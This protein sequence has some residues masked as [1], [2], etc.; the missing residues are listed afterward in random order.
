MKTSE[1]ELKHFKRVLLQK[2][3][4]T[5]NSDVMYN[6][7][8]KLCENL[9]TEIS[10]ITKKI[11]ALGYAEGDFENLEDSGRQIQG[12]IKKLHQQ[13]ERRNAYRFDLQYIDPEPGFNRKK[14]HGMVGKLFDVIDTNHY[15][16]LMITA[17]G[18][19][20]IIKK[21][22][23]KDVYIKCILQLYSHVTDDDVTSKKILQKGQLQQR[24]TIIPIN[25]ISS[26]AINT[27]TVNFAKSLVGKENVNSALSLIAFDSYFDPVMKFVFGHTLICKD[28]NIAKQVKNSRFIISFKIMQI[29]FF[30]HKN[31][32]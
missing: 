20:C 16:A 13:L 31:Y 5:Q 12:E 6:K 26:N 22:D 30:C 7:D 32:L 28:L 2:E 25:K 21:F 4:E 17:G 27:S 1:M 15:L 11:D 18:N 29:P 8:K 9:S 23:E 10:N 14:V 19:V 24:V 3:S